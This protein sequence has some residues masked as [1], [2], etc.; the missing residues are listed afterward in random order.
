MGSISCRW[1]GDGV[2]V[3]T[4][5]YFDGGMWIVPDYLS[6]CIFTDSDFVLMLLGEVIFPSEGRNTRQ[7]K[8][9]FYFVVCCLLSVVGERVISVRGTEHTT[10]K[11]FVA[12][13]SLC[14]FVLLL[15][16]PERSALKSGAQNQDNFEC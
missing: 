16:E 6:R 5:N 10:K 7:K 11:A 9:L 4:L 13:S 15:L 3:A 14:A 8:L 12:L 1:R 2:G